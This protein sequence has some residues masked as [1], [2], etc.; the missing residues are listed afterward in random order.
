[1]AAETLLS[2]LGL[3]HMS[4]NSEDVVAD[5]GADQGQ[6]KAESMSLCIYDRARS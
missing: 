5:S 2:L 1:M 3:P 4:V 6:Y